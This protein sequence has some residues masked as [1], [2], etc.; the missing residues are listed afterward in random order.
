LQAT[1]APSYV[2]PGVVI[3]IGVF[4]DQFLGADILLQPLT[5]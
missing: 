1:T 4:G 5:K 3:T 2:R